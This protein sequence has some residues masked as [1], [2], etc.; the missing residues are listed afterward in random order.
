MKCKN[1]ESV[2]HTEK[3]CPN[4]NEGWVNRLHMYCFYCG[5]RRHNMEAC[6]RLQDSLTSSRSDLHDHYIKDR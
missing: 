6:P 2:G 4:T 1:C 3:N 5:S